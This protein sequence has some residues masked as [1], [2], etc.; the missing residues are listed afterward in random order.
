MVS[1]F[2]QILIIMVDH[3]DFEED[4]F[5]SLRQEEKEVLV[6]N[7]GKIAAFK[8]T[9]KRVGVSLGD[10]HFRYFQTT[11]VV[12][13]YPN[14]IFFLYPNLCN[15]K[16]GLINF[17]ALCQNFERK[18]FL[19]GYLVGADCTL[20]AH[21]YFRR[22]YHEANNFAP[23]FIEH[24]WNADHVDIDPFIALDTDRVRIN[25]SDAGYVELDTWFGAQFNRNVESIADGIVKLRP[26]S[27][28]KSHHVSFFFSDAYSLDIKWAT[29]DKI[30]SFQAEEFKTEQVILYKDGI[31]YYPV[32]YIHAEYVLDEKYFRHFDGAIHF[33]T[34]EEY[35]KR[36]DADF[37]Y[38][39]KNQSKIKTLSQKLFKMNG[40]VSV[41]TWIEYC[42]HFYSGNPLMIEYFSGAY[43]KHI[44][45]MLEMVRSKV[46]KDV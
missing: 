1:C 33:Y 20:M 15:D 14:I 32:R 3:R 34:E 42:S 8:E 12:A 25:V 30:K 46:G 45:E 11:G 9:M 35:Y 24:F 40:K 23:R 29:K 18:H 39:N 41:D 27:D 6:K 19:N 26:P 7:A 43:P 16:E 36:R 13:S 37:N 2:S 44:L 4:Y 21:P 10:E 5:E 38:N 31:R 22:S 28:I 17:K